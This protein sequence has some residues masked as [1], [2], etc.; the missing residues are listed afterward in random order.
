MSHAL[1]PAAHMI[2]AR[3]PVVAPPANW[4]ALA[5]PSTSAAYCIHPSPHVTLLL[6]YLDSICSFNPKLTM[7]LFTA[8]AFCRLDAPGLCRAPGTLAGVFFGA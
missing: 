2:P 7:V 5:H 8:M 1:Q 4:L 6:E 3:V